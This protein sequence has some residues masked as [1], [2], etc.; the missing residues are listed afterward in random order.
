MAKW[1]IAPGSS[2]RSIMWQRILLVMLLGIAPRAEAVNYTDIWYNPS[3]NGWGVNLVQSDAF[4][5]ATFFIYG[6]TGDPT[7]YTANLTRDASGNFNG[8][9]FGTKGTY[10]AAPWNPQ[11]FV[12][13]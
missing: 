9:L 11:A 1:R 2:T 4:M 13:T 6:P 5:F 12:V 7:W 8:G 10:F 3:E